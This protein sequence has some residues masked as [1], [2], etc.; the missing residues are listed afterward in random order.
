MIGGGMDHMIG[1]LIQ[2]NDQLTSSLHKADGALSAFGNTAK[3]TQRQLN[4]LHVPDMNTSGLKK[5]QANWKKLGTTAMAAG[6]VTLAGLGLATRGAMEFEAAMAEVST[7]V[8]TNVVDMKKM[9]NTARDLASKYRQMPVDVARGFYPIVSAG[10]S[11]AAESTAVLTGALKLAIG[12]VTDTATAADGLTSNLNAFGLEASDVGVVSDKMFVAMRA[13]KT[14][15][16]ELSSTLGRASPIAAAAGVSLDELLAATSALTLGG[17]GTAEAVTALRGTLN[18]VIKPSSEASKL[19]E[20]L[21]IQFDTAALKSMG[22]ANWLTMVKEKTGGDQE[23]M[24]KLFGSVEAISGVLAITGNQAGAFATILGDMG[25]AAGQ[26]D[27]AVSKMMGTSGS[28]WAGMRTNVSLLVEQ[29]GEN[30][31]PAVTKISDAI[32][33][34]AE[35]LRNFGE[36]HPILSKILTTTLAITAGLAVIVPTVVFAAK[37]IIPIITAIGAALAALPVGWIIAGVAAV[38]A[39]ITGLAGYFSGAT[40]EIVKDTGIIGSVWSWLEEAFYAVAEPIAY[41]LGYLAATVDDA[42]IA[43]RDYTQEIW[44][45]VQKIIGKVWDWAKAIFGPVVKTLGAIVS[46]GWDLIKHVTQGLF[47]ALVAIIGTG[48]DVITGLFKAALQLLSGDWSGSWET[49]KGTFSVVWEDIKAMFNGIL[50]WIKALGP[51]FWN[52]GASLIQSLADGMIAASDRV[53]AG[54]ITD[55]ISDA[56]PGSGR[57]GD[58]IIKPLKKSGEGATQAFASGWRDSAAQLHST[59]ANVLAGVRDLLPGSDAKTGP[60]SDLTASGSALFRTFAAGMQA[61]DAAPV[62]IASDALSGI[63]LSPQIGPLSPTRATEPTQEKEPAGRQVVFQR[64]AFQISVSGAE[65]VDDLESRLEAVFGR[66]A[67]QL[68]G[69]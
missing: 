4:G 41:G 52:A 68:G 6:T 56:L 21:G 45:I 22:L 13:G 16:G 32:G 35:G 7:L 33:W 61:T 42:W 26:T 43:I 30:L 1:V 54:A 10:F 64:G 47:D 36:A 5:S 58:V 14:T 25:T 15:I 60:L 50:E 27:L 29:I 11:G 49:I 9:S 38:G 3:E 28:A 44:P 18:A 63:N 48:W 31:A 55:W 19:A 37:F 23:A 53:G 39:A 40:D 8:D 57:G 67:L 34:V 24:A 62:K 69:A 51:M 20:E 59:A 12:G 65:S 46:V 17:L 2:G 66:I